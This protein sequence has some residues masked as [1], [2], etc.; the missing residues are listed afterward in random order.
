VPVSA[1]DF[2]QALR[3]W[4]SGVSIVTTRRESGILGITVSSLCSLSLQPPLVL[5]CIARTAK[6]H[7]AI[8]DR[9]SFGVNILRADQ[10][11]LANRAAG[12]AGERGAWLEGV[13]WRTEA[14]GA[15]ILRD[16]LGW[17]D[18]SLVDQPD[19]GDHTI[20]IG[21]VEAAG[22]SDGPPLVWF[23]SGYRALGEVKRARSRRRAAPAP[24]ISR[25]RK[26]R[27]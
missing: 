2:K 7:A 13:A 15:P 8:R 22:G 3:R 27:R 4:A 18:C 10:A 23:H 12:R 20:Y 26:R 16:C 25:I 1:D 24:K 5:V 9:R 19:G 17:L 11:A 14:T 6:S 21:R